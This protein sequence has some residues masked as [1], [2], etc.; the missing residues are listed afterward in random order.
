MILQ[1]K[2]ARTLHQVAERARLLLLAVAL[3]F[4]CVPTAYALRCP[5]PG[6]PLDSPASRL[7]EETP[8]PVQT[9]YY[10][11]WAEDSEGRIGLFVGNSPL[12]FADPYGLEISVFPGLSESVNAIRDRL[13]D[14][15]YQAGQ[16]LYDLMMGD[17]PGQY[18]PNVKGVL[19]AEMGMGIDPG[20]NVLRDSLGEAGVVVAG[21]LDAAAEA[22]LTGKI[23]DLPAGTRCPAKPAAKSEV[24]ALTKFYPENAGFAG[25]TERT[26]LMPGQ[27]ID[28]YGGSGYSRFFSP[29]GTPDWARSLPPGT[30]GQPLRTFEVVKPFEVQSGTVAPWFNQPG[31]GLQY[32]T[33]V[34]LETLLNR[35]IIRE[36]TP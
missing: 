18:N 12:T 33:P 19:D 8:G 24:T 34:K 21:M 32:V 23:L 20:N 7:N 28:R 6:P 9:S 4:C 11:V 1:K 30:A 14:D 22:Y 2:A 5:T 13:Q 25:A 26:F 27:T 15:I 10:V 17:Q 31:G 16:G 3:L 36:V 29:Q 35:G